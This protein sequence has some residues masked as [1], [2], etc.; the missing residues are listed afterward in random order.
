MREE[1]S[2]SSD[3]QGERLYEYVPIWD[4]KVYFRYAPRRVDCDIHGPLGEHVPLGG[5][6]GASDDQRI[7]CS[8]LGGPGVLRGRRRLAYSRPVGTVYF[9]RSSM[10]WNT[11]SPTAAW[12]VSSRSVLMRLAMEGAD[13][14]LVYQLDKQS[15]RLLWSGTEAKSK[16]LTPVLPR[17]RE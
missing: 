1:V 10:W 13:L 17:V 15:R 2:R 11:A 7:R 9:G 5:G 8:L 16:D 14:F 4:F 3:T 12:M 6:Q